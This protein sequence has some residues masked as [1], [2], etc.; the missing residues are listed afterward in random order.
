[1]Q[2]EPK[3]LNTTSRLTRVGLGFSFILVLFFLTSQLISHDQTQNRLAQQWQRSDSVAGVE[4]LVKWPS[5][6]LIEDDEGTVVVDVI[7]DMGWTAPFTLTVELPPGISNPIGGRAVEWGMMRENGRYQ[8][9]TIAIENAA[10]LRQHTTQPI[11]ISTTLNHTLSPLRVTLESSNG[12][13]TRYFWGNLINQNGPLLL[14]IAAVVSITSLIFQEQERAKN[15]QL[16]QNEL[17]LKQIELA[18]RQEEREQQH[19][20][21][22]AKQRQQQDEIRLK[23]LELAQKQDEREQ[24]RQQGQEKQRQQQIEREKNRAR[25]KIV[26]QTNKLHTCLL[27]ADKINLLRL[28]PTVDQTALQEIEN[29][30]WLTLLVELS[31]GT[32]PPPEADTFG[33]I[34]ASWPAEAAG[35][36]LCAGLKD[37]ALYD[38]I[39]LEKVTDP[40]LRNQLI[41]TQRGRLPLQDWPPES[42]LPGDV[43][44]KSPLE[45]TPL[46]QIL[47][48]DPLLHER[49]E[50]ELNTLSNEGAFWIEHPRYSQIAVATQN[51]IVLGAR[52]SGRTAL[53]RALCYYE[54]QFQRHY[55][56]YTNS[57]TAYHLRTT[58]AE[59]LLQYVL[60]KPTLLSFLQE[61]QRCLLGTVLSQ[62]LSPAYVLAKLE[63]G[64]S[65]GGWYNLADANQKVTWRTVGETQLEMLA[66]CVKEDSLPVADWPLACHECFAM[67]GFRG[68]RLVLDLADGEA[69][70]YAELKVALHDWRQ[71]GV[72]AT[73]FIPDKDLATWQKDVT[74]GKILILDWSQDQLDKLIHHRFNKLAN[75]EPHWIFKM[76]AYQAFLDNIQT[77]RD[78]IILW[79]ATLQH[80]DWQPNDIQILPGYITQGR[81]ALQEESHI[82][83]EPDLGPVWQQR[84]KQEAYELARKIAEHFSLN[85]LEDLCYALGVKYEELPGEKTRS[86]KS[87]ELVEYM[88]R[89]GRFPELRERLQQ[90]RPRVQW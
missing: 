70:A 61:K 27:N 73:V 53:A 7:G 84:E 49:A 65:Q 6:L 39:P 59:Q 16:R 14:V 20:Q 9:Q 86:A 31:L 43:I 36:F 11:T 78:M 54:P 44:A 33:T 62:A 69:E 64:L 17:R 38:K 57:T 56:A 4:L 45:S 28:W 74:G 50:D 5:H 60:S 3:T 68:L 18:Q 42:L 47:S 79:S 12:A 2:E 48:R 25:Q 40:V 23:E 13:A 87:R 46:A 55:W 21:E 15:L 63:Q 67:L 77:P 1:M 82:T 72:V 83:A 26:A 58:L 90:E 22:Q 51:Q 88:T 81:V 19:Q 8:Q 71:A 41:Q 85:E 32:I 29:H 89:H 34:A 80:A 75:R 76:D 66:Q 10:T 24:Q 37:K 35:A 52:G 30:D